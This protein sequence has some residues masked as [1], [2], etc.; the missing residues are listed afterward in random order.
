MDEYN[1]KFCCYRKIG[2]MYIYNHVAVQGFFT[3]ARFFYSS[4]TSSILVLYVQ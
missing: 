1:H 2:I 4:A 3:D